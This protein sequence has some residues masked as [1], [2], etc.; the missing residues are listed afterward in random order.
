MCLFAYEKSNKF[1]PSTVMSL[2]R[3]ISGKLLT[4]LFIDCIENFIRIR[5]ESSMTLFTFKQICNIS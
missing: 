3:V 5:G 1:V 4:K 2:S